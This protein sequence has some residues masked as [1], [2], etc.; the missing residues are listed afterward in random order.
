M[1]PAEVGHGGW[2]GGI[3]LAS[4]AVSF[5]PSCQP[6]RGSLGSWKAGADPRV[7]CQWEEERQ[8]GNLWSSL[9]SAGGRVRKSPAGE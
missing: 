5:L 1:R 3:S 4:Q 6:H 9:L 7:W 8:P 2:R